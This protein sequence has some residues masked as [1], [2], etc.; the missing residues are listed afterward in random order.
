M[1]LRR[2]QVSD[3]FFSRLCLI[4]C[5]CIPCVY[6]PSVQ[7]RIL[8]E[9]QGG[10][11]EAD[12]LLKQVKTAMLMCMG[13]LSEQNVRLYGTMEQ[14]HVQTCASLPLFVDARI[15]ALLKFSWALSIEDIRHT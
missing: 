3:V 11:Y 5:T 13:G 8:D 10:M 2:E 12:I 7:V 1:N 4:F 9:A 14:S 6:L 15:V